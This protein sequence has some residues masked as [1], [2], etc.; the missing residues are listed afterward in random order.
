LFQ[1][2]YDRYDEDELREQE[3]SDIYQEQYQNEGDDDVDVEGNSNDIAT[4]SSR[5]TLITLHTP[6]LSS[7][8]NYADILSPSLSALDNTDENYNGIIGLLPEI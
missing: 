5:D 7:L 2:S 6:P 1:R 4:S 3:N 8:G